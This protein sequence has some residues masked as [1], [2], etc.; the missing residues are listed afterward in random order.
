MGKIG[1]VTL[2][3]DDYDEAID[4][5]TKVVGF[6]LLEDAPL[7]DKRWVV[8]RPRGSG[9]TALLLAKAVDERQRSRIG[10]QT[11]GRVAFFLESDDFTS[12][13]ERMRGAGASFLED[14]RS[15]EYGQVAVFEDLYGNRW[16]L[17]E[18]L[19]AP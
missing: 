5:Y 12:D 1:L 17:I 14:P 19:G 16:D 4:F 10:D 2:V 8:V 15:E 3:V 11:G 7:G 13:Y 18:Y 9:G 6:E